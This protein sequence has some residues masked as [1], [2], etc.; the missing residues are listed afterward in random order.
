MEKFCPRYRFRTWRNVYDFVD[1]PNVSIPG[2]MPDF[3]AAN[4]NRF[5]RGD[6]FVA[7]APALPAPAFAGPVVAA[8]VAK[9]CPPGKILNPKTRRCVK[10]LPVAALGAKVCPPGKILN[11]K[12]RR[13]VKVRPAAA[14]PAVKICQHGKVMNPKT[15]RC[16]KATG[17]AGKAA[18]QR[19]RL[20]LA[21]SSNSSRSSGFSNSPIPYAD[22]DLYSTDS[23]VAPV[24]PPKKFC[25]PGKILNPKTM[26]CVN[27][28]GGV[29]RRINKTKKLR[30]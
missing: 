28:K 26:R 3:V 2:S 18:I 20:L 1:R 16:V 29:A 30:R 24:P 13:C 14:A 21:P 27:E 4:M 15:G 17:A 19:A 22:S 10:A 11:P 9:V 25:P 6:P 12:T 7:P 23:S 8:P 5:M